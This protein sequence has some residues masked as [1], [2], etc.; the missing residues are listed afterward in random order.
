MACIQD[1]GEIV[2]FPIVRSNICHDIHTDVRIVHADGQ[3]LAEKPLECFCYHHRCIRTTVS[4]QIYPLE[5]K[6]KI[7][8]KIRNCIELSRDEKLE[9]YLL[10]P[11]ECDCRTMVTVASLDEAHHSE[12]F[13]DNGKIEN[14]SHSNSIDLMWLNNFQIKRPEY[15]TFLKYTKR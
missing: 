3:R 8:I 2:R 1:C 10:W 15:I 12:V 14:H 5:I 7:I 9:I 6:T 11:V 4:A 13:D